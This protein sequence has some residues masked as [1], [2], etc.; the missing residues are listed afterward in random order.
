MAKLEGTDWAGRISTN[1][2]RRRDDFSVQFSLPDAPRFWARVLLPL[3]RPI[4][5]SDFLLGDLTDAEAAEALTAVLRDL[6]EERVA[7]IEFSHLG[8]AGSPEAMDQVARLGKVVDAYVLGSHR[9]VSSRSVVVDRGKANLRI[10]F[11][12]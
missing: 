3:T 7:S 5:F 6:G 2:L 11:W 4:R 10:Q 12:E 8:D 9:F 1:L